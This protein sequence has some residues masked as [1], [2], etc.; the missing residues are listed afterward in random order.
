MTKRELENT[1]RQL[2]ELSDQALPEQLPTIQDALLQAG[3][4]V[5]ATDISAA[6]GRIQEIKSILLGLGARR[7]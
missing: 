1:M 5:T 7:R 6:M 4:A 3:R 2:H